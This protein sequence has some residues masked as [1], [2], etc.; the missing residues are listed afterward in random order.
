MGTDT[1]G[2]DGGTQQVFRRWP[3]VSVASFLLKIGNKKKGS[4]R[5]EQGIFAH[6]CPSKPTT[7]ARKGGIS[8]LN[9]Q[10]NASSIGGALSR[11]RN[12]AAS[13]QYIV[14]H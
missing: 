3:R 9:T 7:P 13:I 8:N 11:L 10:C 5:S 6:A 2:R 4:F 1:K 12:P 14:L